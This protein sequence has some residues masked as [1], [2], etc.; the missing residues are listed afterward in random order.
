MNY[1]LNN[2]DME[3]NVSRIVMGKN[4]FGREIKSIGTGSH[5][6]YFLLLED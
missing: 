5:Q 2:G 3:I 4:I 6:Y 1:K